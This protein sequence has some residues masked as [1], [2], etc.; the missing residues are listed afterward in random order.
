MKQLSIFDVAPGLKESYIYKE[1][2]YKKLQKH[3]R[4]LCS[5]VLVVNSSK[6]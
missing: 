1:F 3:K 6:E 2:L 4:R 5:S